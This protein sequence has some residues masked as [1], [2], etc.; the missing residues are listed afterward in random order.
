MKIT[1]IANAAC[2]YESAGYRILCDPWLTPGAF[3]G[4]WFHTRPLE[5]LEHEINDYDLLYISHLHPDH[6][7]PETLMF[8][9]KT[10]P[11]VI[12]ERKSN[13]LKRMLERDGFTNIVEMKHWETRDFGPFSLSMFEPFCGHPFS[14]TEIGNP[15]DSAILVEDEYHTVLN[16]NDNTLTIDWAKAIKELFPELTVA[17]LNY[18]NAG[19]YPACFTN[20]SEQDA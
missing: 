4:S 3:Y 6:Y 1:S 14:E 9:D 17:Q 16:A 7:D 5:T 2:I 15:I 12:L 11:V 18:N 8:F 13:Y 20:L 19:P 10:K